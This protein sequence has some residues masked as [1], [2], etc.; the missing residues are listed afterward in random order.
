MLLSDPLAGPAETQVADVRDYPEWHKGRARYGAW[1]ALIE[2]PALL[3]Y[4]DI[5]RHRLRDLLH[6]CPQRQP[7]LTVFVCGFEQ[8][9]RVEH[10]D[11][12]PDALAR[13]IACLEHDM[14]APCELP[15]APPDSFASAAFIPVGDPQRR[16]ARWR[17]SLG[18]VSAEIRQSPYVPHITLGLYR[19]RVS[20]A[21]LRQRLGALEAPTMALDMTRLVYVTYAASEL[22]GALQVQHSVPMRMPASAGTS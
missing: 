20:A 11:F 12:P 7:H 22:F 3:A 16:L 6:P 14:A 1:V 10:D 8:P 19:Q 17:Q 4:I 13:Q 5:C 15:L 21:V 18:Q 2:Q 9:A